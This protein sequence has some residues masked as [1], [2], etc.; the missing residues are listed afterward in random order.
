MQSAKYCQ[1]YSGN[2]MLDKMSIWLIW[3]CGALLVK[4]S[5]LEICILKF[6]DLTDTS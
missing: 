5:D 2:A 4:F 1:R 6:V 3:T